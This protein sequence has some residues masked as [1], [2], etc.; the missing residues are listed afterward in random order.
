VNDKDMQ[1]RYG[2][3]HHLDG[4][5]GIDWVVVGGESGSDARPMHPS[6]ARNLR[7]QCNT[8]GVPFLFKQW[9]EWIGG[10]TGWALNHH[11][12]KGLPC[13]SWGDGSLSM[14]IGIKNSGRLL[15]GVL[16]DDYPAVVG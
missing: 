14:R 15:D 11:D 5:R 12:P 6:W 1:A 13:N 3:H 2:S 4:L 9:G 7:D 16:H 8:A 10:G